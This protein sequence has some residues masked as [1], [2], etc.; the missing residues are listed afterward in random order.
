MDNFYKILQVERLADETEIK[1]AYIRLLKEYLPEKA[2]EEFKRI[3]KAYEMFIDP[4]SRAEYDA[5]N[6]MRSIK[7][8]K[9]EYNIL[10]INRCKFYDEAYKI[11]QRNIKIGQQIPKS[12]RDKKSI[13]DSNTNVAD[14]IFS[15]KGKKVKNVLSKSLFGCG[16]SCSNFS[17]NFSNTK[18][19]GD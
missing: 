15:T 7:I 14:K 19:S 9:K 17:S 3:R 11:D 16:G 13:V 2:P 6:V 12:K 18:T 8:L 1:R 4:I 10:Y 5:L